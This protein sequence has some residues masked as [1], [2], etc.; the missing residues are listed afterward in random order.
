MSW[1]GS[2]LAVAVRQVYHHRSTQSLPLYNVPLN[3]IS[4][5][6][7]SI[8][9]ISSPS[10]MSRGRIAE[11]ADNE[12]ELSSFAARNLPRARTEGSSGILLDRPD[13]SEQDSELEIKLKSRPKSANRVR[14]NSTPVQVSHAVSSRV[15]SGRQSPVQ[16][17]LGENVSQ[18]IIQEKPTR[19]ASPRPESGSSPPV[20][21]AKPSGNTKPEI[22]AHDQSTETKEKKDKPETVWSRAHGQASELFWENR[23]VAW[24][25][26]KMKDWN[27]MK[28][29]LRCAVAVNTA[30]VDD[31][32]PPR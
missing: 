27:E 28:P 19:T 1:I 10:T 15:Q 31:E 8:R 32:G 4:C 2:R 22:P 25:Y 29:V 26:P 13:L 6:S 20:A 11:D 9:N 16:E 23:H 3:L 5:H 7:P 21:F 14:L 12:V 17:G 24:M 18:G 30:S